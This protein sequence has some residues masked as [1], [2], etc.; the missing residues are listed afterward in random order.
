MFNVGSFCFWLLCIIVM[1]WAKTLSRFIS[2]DLHRNSDHSEVITL[3]HCCTFA[4]Q[5]SIGFD[6]YFFFYWDNTK[7]FSA[8]VDRNKIGSSTYKHKYS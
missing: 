3:K 4:F 8:N 5:T 6:V 1:S 7:T 2:S